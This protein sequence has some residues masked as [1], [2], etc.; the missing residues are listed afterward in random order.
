M[1]N[2]NL[3]DRKQFE[4]WLRQ[5]KREVCVAIAARAALRVLPVL[6]TAFVGRLKN[7]AVTA[8]VILPV[9]RAMALPLAA[10]KYPARGNELRAAARAASAAATPA[11]RAPADIASAASGT[12]A[13]NAFAASAAVRAADFASV[14]FGSVDA[15]FAAAFATPAAFAARDARFINEGGSAETLARQPP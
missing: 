2:V 15:D 11:V 13:D 6:V 10:A 4:A 9:I 7:S 5:Q 14:D 12:P 3:S 1:A 8:A